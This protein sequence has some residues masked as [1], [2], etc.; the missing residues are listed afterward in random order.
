[1]RQLNPVLGSRS[2]I[3][4][5]FSMC[6]GWYDIVVRTDLVTFIVNFLHKS[7]NSQDVLL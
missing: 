5:I 4:A 7:V 1:M 3:N 2:W 6:F